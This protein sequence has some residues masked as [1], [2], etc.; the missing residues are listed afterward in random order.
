MNSGGECSA[1]TTKMEEG[2]S[3][4]RGTAD[5]FSL[6]ILIRTGQVIQMSA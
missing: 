6:E 1:V 3:N 2:V 4:R 5:M